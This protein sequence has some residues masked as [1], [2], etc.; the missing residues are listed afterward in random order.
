MHLTCLLMTIQST[1]TH[2][3]LSSI[4]I[5]VMLA[6]YNFWL[7]RYEQKFWKFCVIY[8]P[9]LYPWTGHLLY[10]HFFSH[11]TRL[12]TLIPFLVCV[13][14]VEEKRL[15][16]EVITSS[17]GFFFS[18]P[19][20]AASCILMLRAPHSHQWTP[21]CS[22]SQAPLYYRLPA[23]RS[24]VMRLLASEVEKT[25]SVKSASAT[26]FCLTVVPWPQ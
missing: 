19:S 7:K 15:R 12:I 14:Q 20:V 24:E 9:F 8:R 23:R 10:W 5:S 4:I 13:F 22:P 25:G 2:R 17:W 21:L 6:T 11:C 1:P 16:P 3:H 18:A 26:Y